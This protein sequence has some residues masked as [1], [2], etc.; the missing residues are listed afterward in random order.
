MQDDVNE[1]WLL[2]FDKWLFLILTHLDME[3]EYWEESDAEIAKN[4][5]LPPNLDATE[6]ELNP[7]Q[8]TL[9]RWIELFIS[10]FQRYGIWASILTLFR[11]F[12]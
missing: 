3:T 10:L 9:I 8:I 1:N 6:D 7:E 2:N 11:Q 12:Q 4:L 5:E